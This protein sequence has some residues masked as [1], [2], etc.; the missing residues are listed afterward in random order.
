MAIPCNP[1][2]FAR[3]IAEGYVPFSRATLKKFSAGELKTIS[4]NLEVVV[5]EFRSLAVPLEDMQ[6]IQHKNQVLQRANSA[7]MVIRHHAKKQRILL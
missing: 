2:L 5:R 7:L 3:N 4:R 1:R 6:L